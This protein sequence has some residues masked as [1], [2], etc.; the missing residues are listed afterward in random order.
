MCRNR[1]RPRNATTEANGVNQP[2][3]GSEPTVRAYLSHRPIVHL[4]M[5]TDNRPQRLAT[6]VNCSQN[7]ARQAPPPGDCA[8]RLGTDDTIDGG[9]R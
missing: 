5:E 3:Q 6:G 2:L 9:G 1:S 7:A 4:P 8:R